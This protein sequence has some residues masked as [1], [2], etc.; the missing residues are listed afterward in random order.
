MECCQEL[1]GHL[2]KILTEHDALMHKLPP[3]AAT[4]KAKGK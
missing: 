2:D 1:A 4:G 3:K